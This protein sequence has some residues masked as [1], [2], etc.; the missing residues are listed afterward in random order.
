MAKSKERKTSRASGDSKPSA[1]PAFLS[2]EKAIDPSLASLF[3]SS[4][5]AVRPPPL[6]RYQEAEA[7]VEQDDEDLPDADEELSE[8]PS[9]DDGSEISSQT[10]DDDEEEKEEDSNVKPTKV[11][12]NGQKNQEGR[13]RKRADAE[14]ALEDLYMRRL[15]DKEEKTAK[16]EK[17]QAEKA[18]KR[19]RRDTE[20]GDGSEENES[21]EEDEKKDADGL[22]DEED[23]DGSSGSEAEEDGDDEIPQ[24]ESLVS[25]KDEGELERASR[26]VFLGNVAV[27]AVESKSDKKTLLNHLAS[28]ISSLPASDQP[29]KVEALRFR[30]VAFSEVGIPK[31]AAFA[32]K[33]VME[34][35][36]KSCN[37][38]AVYST[39]VA[40]REATKRLNGTIVLD[41]HLRVDSVSHPAKSDHKRCVFVGNLG[42]VDDESFIDD[43]E[44]ENGKK[45]PQKKKKQPSD[46]EEGL[47]REFGKAGTVESVRVVRDPKT[48]VGKGFAYVQFNDAN[49]V[50]AALLFNDKKFPPLLPRKLRVVR[51]KAMKKKATAKNSSAKVNSKAIYNPKLTP[52]QKSLQGR[53]GKLLGRAGAAKM[54]NGDSGNA[55]QRPVVPRPP[56]SFVFEGY[57]ASNKSGKQ[58]LKLGGSG[59]KKGKPRTRSS[60]RGT[61]WKASGGQKRTK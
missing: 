61:A 32:R 27:S 42:F 34:A 28:F 46:V 54:K 17:K 41:R 16:K 45:K 37:A 7:A 12:I 30:S 44:V 6:S 53:A 14:E 18:S 15:A 40:A 38:Y 23:S 24:H 36:T 49:A 60:R 1:P 4:A 8:L 35:T 59:K 43:A 25:S 3:A 21:E 29:H 22:S 55:K 11:E 5:G 33:D 51:A 9:E 50:E 39:A 26:T 58:G 2:N 20:A 31:K 56:E 19:Q 47:W 52:E 10:D 57:R 48:R 13:K